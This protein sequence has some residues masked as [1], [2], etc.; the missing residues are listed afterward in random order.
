MAYD[1]YLAERIAQNLSQ[2]NVFYEG[3]KMFGGL[4]FMVHEKMCVGVMKDQLMARINPAD[5]AQLLEKEGA[6]PMD[7]SGISMKGFLLIAPDGC[8]TDADLEFWIDA[9]LAFNPLAK[10]SAKRQKKPKQSL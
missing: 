9:C 3:K 1:T 7:F 5:A 4:C 10:A 6:A 8:D 2:K